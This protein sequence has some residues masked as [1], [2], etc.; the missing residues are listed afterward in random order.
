M[1]TYSIIQRNKSQGFKTWYL[2]IYDNENG[3]TTFKSL[4]TENKHQAAEL[5]RQHINQASESGEAGERRKLEKIYLKSAFADYLKQLETQNASENTITT[6]KSMIKGFIDFCHAMNIDTL[7]ETTQQTA[8]AFFGSMNTKPSTK[9]RAHTILKTFYKWVLEFYD[10]DQKNIFSKVKTPKPETSNRFFWTNEQIEQILQA[11]NDKR[12]RLL[13][14][15]CA[16]Q[17]LRFTEAA[18][19]QWEQVKSDSLEIIG[20]GRKFAKI[21]LSDKMKAEFIKAG[22]RKESGPIFAK[23]FH[24]H[25][26]NKILQDLC[27][28]LFIEDNTPIHLHRFRHSFGSNLLKAGVNVVSV[29]KLMRHE[30][31]NITLKYYAH[32]LAEDLTE[33]I[34]KL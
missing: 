19:L 24:N 32:V 9:R 23:R 28:K 1:K 7:K 14:A 30:N 12:R 3:K 2:R 4:K 15:L 5:M 34:N 29:S 18:G 27:K 33:A 11:V 8:A 10:I 17:G 26:E 31:A 13:Y 25:I 6:Y 16:Y 22:G 20:K 21:P